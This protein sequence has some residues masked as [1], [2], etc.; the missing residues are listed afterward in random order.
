[1]NRDDYRRVT[2]VSTIPA[3]SRSVSGSGSA[4]GADR[5]GAGGGDAA[6]SLTLV[7]RRDCHLCEEMAAV[8]EAVRAAEAC[9]LEVRDVDADPDLL[10]RYSDQVPVLLVSGRRAFKYRVTEAALARRLR[11]ERRRARWRAWWRG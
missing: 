11:A 6:V 7:T 8:V 1:M 3:R 10:A 5:D 4:A 2:A 9:T